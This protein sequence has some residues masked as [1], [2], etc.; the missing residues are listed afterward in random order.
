MLRKEARPRL[1]EAVDL[2]AVLGTPLNG[3]FISG[4]Q[5]PDCPPGLLDDAGVL[6]VEG[7]S[8]AIDAAGAGRDAPVAEVETREIDIRTG[9]GG[10]VVNSVPAV[11]T[12]FRRRFT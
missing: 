9:K 5:D 6:D 2:D 12:G 3:R 7:Y 11:L 8:D 10:K 1:R 4:H